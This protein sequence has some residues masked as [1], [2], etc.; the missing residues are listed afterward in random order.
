TG[1][2][3]PR[4]GAGRIVLGVDVS[5]W[6]RP[7]AATAPER[8]F[9]HVYGRGKSAAQLIPGWPYSFVA[10]LEPGRTSW[11]AVLDVV[12][13]GPL[14][15]VTKVTAAQVRAVVAR[16]GGPSGGTAHSAGYVDPP[17]GGPAAWRS[18][19]ETGL[20]VDFGDRARCVRCGPTLAVVSAPLRPGTHVPAVQTNTGLDQTTHPGPEDSRTLNLANE[21][22]LHPTPSGPGSHQRPTPPVGATSH[23]TGQADPRPGTTR[24]P[25]PTRETTRSRRRAETYPARTRPP[26]RLPQ[27]ARRSPSTRR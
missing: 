7:D 19:P 18:P 22:R 26:T 15:D 9:C 23:P 27:Q 2:P 11:T 20:A 25:S 12:R 13:L 24:V 10:A 16:L 3:R 14:D 6:L 8:S 4:D 1:L 5:N 21:R 17:R